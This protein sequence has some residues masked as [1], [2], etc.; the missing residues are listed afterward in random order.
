MIFY[1][2]GIALAIGMLAFYIALKMCLTKAKMKQGTAELFC[3]LAVPV[4]LLMSRLVFSV[5]S[6][7]YFASTISQPLKMLY[8]FDGGYSMTGA[9]LGFVIAG[10]LTAKIQ[11]ISFGKL[12]DHVAILAC[13]LIVIERLAEGFTI[14][15][16]GRE[17][18]TQ[19]LRDSAFFAVLDG[20]DTIC[21][22]VYR[23]EAVAAGILLVVMLF[24]R[25][26]R[27]RSGD[28]ALACISLYGA[29]QIIF[30]SMRDDFHML[31][32]F[33]RAQQ[34]YAIFMPIIAIVILSTRIK[35]RSGDI[36]GLVIPWVITALGI[37]LGII[38]EFDIDTSANL[39][40][41]YGIM[42]LAVAMV[43]GVSLYLIR[44]T[45]KECQSGL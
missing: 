37:I 29:A 44:L 42:A 32:G 31:W 13:G 19:A 14:L 39:F 27:W 16:I 15:G 4:S 36:Y 6:V 28:T 30:E 11:R 22:A 21:H 2:Y 20:S 18:K 26:Q 12:M 9:I 41:D 33:V 34:V 5:T 7:M 24:L 25:K 3:V 10:A 45:N 1:P 38:K 40:M 8:F 35:K 17:I 43:A 23:Y